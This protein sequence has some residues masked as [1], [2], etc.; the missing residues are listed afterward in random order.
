MR[1]DDV[2]K[3]MSDKYL[4]GGGGG[5]GGGG[6]YKLQPISDRFGCYVSG[7]QL[8]EAAGRCMAVRNDRLMSKIEADLAEHRILLF[9][10]QGKL[11]AEI[12]IK[13]SEH[14]GTVQS[15]FYKHPKSPHKDIFRVSNDENEGCTRVGRSGWHIDGTFLQRPFAV[16]IMPTTDDALL[17]SECFWFYAFLTVVYSG[18]CS[19]MHAAKTVLTL[20]NYDFQWKFLR[21]LTFGHICKK[22]QRPFLFNNVS[23]FSLTLLDNQP[24]IIPILACRTLIAVSPLN[25][26]VETLDSKER[27]EWDRLFFVGDSS[28]H[29]LMYPHPKTGKQ[30]LCFHLGGPFF[31]GFARD[32]GTE[33]CR[34]DILDPEE[35][36]C[37]KE[38]LLKLLED[39]KRNISIQWK[40]GDFAILDNLAVAHFASPGTQDSRKKSGLRILHRLYD[41]R[42][43]DP[44][45]RR[46][47]ILPFVIR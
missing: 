20:D 24:V 6:E 39:P 45:F 18:N 46:N 21:F 43:N 23:R 14:F 12:Q 30:T 33:E 27:Q 17:V 16:Q 29:P 2:Q 41:Y 8:R 9:R 3:A 36:K 40:T 32:S 4:E 22:I 31:R 25:E 47:S 28:V 15:T 11:S 13:I 35:S 19:E 34:A 42:K 37:I 26:I 38:R 1:S 44:T 7:I 5:G 10:G